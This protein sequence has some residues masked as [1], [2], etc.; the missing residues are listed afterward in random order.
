L[1]HVAAVGGSWMAERKTV[2]ER[3]WSKITALTAEAM[4]T[5]AS[6]PSK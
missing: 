4:K 1:P 5:I 3:A 2:A 6:L